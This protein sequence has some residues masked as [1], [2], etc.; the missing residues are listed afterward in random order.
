MLELNNDEVVIKITHPAPAEYV[1]G[2]QRG[3]LAVVKTVLSTG[4]QGEDPDI[5]RE[6][7]E[8]CVH[9]LELLEATLIDPE[10]L[11]VASEVADQVSKL[12]GS[13]SS[14]RDQLN[15]TLPNEEKQS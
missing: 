9:A 3:I 10:I 1:D 5:D 2:L 12:K 4:A 7:A 15:Q 11:V 8:G 6:T 14:I 13:V